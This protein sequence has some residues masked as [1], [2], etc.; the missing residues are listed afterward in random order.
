MT[1]N[2]AEFELNTATD[3]DTT[4]IGSLV[5]KHEQADPLS[6]E[7]AIEEEIDKRYEKRN[8]TLKRKFKE[9][10]GK[11]DAFNKTSKLNRAA[12]IGAWLSILGLAG[13]CAL[14]SF[15]VTFRINEAITAGVS[16]IMAGIE[17][18]W[19]KGVILGGMA[20]GFFGEGDLR[21]KAIKGG[22]GMAAMGAM[23]LIGLNL[24]G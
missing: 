22:I 21:T 12:K 4:P 15:A 11:N 8:V 1:L 18:H 14:D 10:I 3:N 5:V 20:G 23:A 24:F 13:F 19:G 16:P 17:A 2:T 7:D 9:A 6:E